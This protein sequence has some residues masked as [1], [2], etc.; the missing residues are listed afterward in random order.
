M[1]HL[2]VIERRK[3]HRVWRP[4][5]RGVASCDTRKAAR[6]ELVWWRSHE[7]GTKTYRLVKYVPEKKGGE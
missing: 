1:R 4:F 2:W 5:W 7:R 6:K 3:R